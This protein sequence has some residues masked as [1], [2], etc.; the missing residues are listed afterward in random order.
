[1]RNNKLSFSKLSLNKSSLNKSSINKP[2]T[3][4]SSIDKSLTRES[5]TRE[6][7]I[8]KSIPTK[9]ILSK[10]ISHKHILSKSP[11]TKFVSTKST[12]NK[13]ATDNP[14]LYKSDTDN[15]T[16]YKSA[17][18]NSTLH[19]SASVDSNRFGNNENKKKIHRLQKY[20]SAEC[21]E[22]L[23]NVS[24]K[25]TIEPNS[26]LSIRL[27]N[28]FKNDDYCNFTNLYIIL[29]TI[30]SK[31]Y[32]FFD[33]LFKQNL[34][35]IFDF[36][37]VFIIN[38]LS[39]PF[40]TYC[41]IQE[42]KQDKMYFRDTTPEIQ[43][44]YYLI[45]INSIIKECETINF[46]KQIHRFPKKDNL[47]KWGLHTIDASFTYILNLPNRIHFILNK[48]SQISNLFGKNYLMIIL[49]ILYLRIINPIIVS[50]SCPDNIRLS[51]YIQ[52]KVNDI[53]NNRY[54]FDRFNDSLDNLEQK[55]VHSVEYIKNINHIKTM[56]VDCNKASES[57]KHILD[58]L[59]INKNCI[60][61]LNNNIHNSIYD[62]IQYL[63]KNL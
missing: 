24:R 3:D 28:I 20:K 6:L 43:C 10:S 58:F 48:I 40:F 38:N 16:L 8:N 51:K 22:Y 7:S 53:I 2:L 9:S 36:Y 13:S 42:I 35:T 55:I 29:S 1:M 19:K 4:E 50:V 11:S 52:R 62:K 23:S 32:Q 33:I 26:T 21:G 41:I 61:W 31:E 49:S 46:L 37:Y 45:D 59:I 17:T 39:I 47:A 57:V 34:E 5:S 27:I 25:I 15:P 63:Q 14:T 30:I 18:S 12:L 44:I 60:T 54:S 56:I